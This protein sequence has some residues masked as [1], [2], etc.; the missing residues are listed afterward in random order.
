MR[1]RRA[2][3]ELI[4]TS[5]PVPL[6]QQHHCGAMSNPNAPNQITDA[7]AA[8]IHSP[9]ALAASSLH[10]TP[11]SEEEDDGDLNKALGVQRFQQILSPAAVVPDE[12]HHNYHEEDIEYHRHSSHHIHRP[13][14]KL[15]SEGRKKKCSKK[16]KKDKDHKSSH[17]PS[18]GP[19][20]E[21]EDEEEEEEEGMGATSAPSDSERVR[22]VEVI[23]WLRMTL[24]VT[25]VVI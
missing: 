12:Q 13:L 4:Q 1:K 10:G 22:D 8:V 25:V 7:M 17:V 15:P 14:S 18:S 11:Q 6:Q 20:E 3:V 2:K 23:I 9:E 5:F 24:T 16:R 21:G 19:I